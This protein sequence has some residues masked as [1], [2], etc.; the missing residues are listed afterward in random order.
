MRASQG[1]TAIGS[2]IYASCDTTSGGPNYLLKSSD[3]GSTWTKVADLEA[4]A[5]SLRITTNGTDTLY[6]MGGSGLFRR[7]AL[8]GTLLYSATVAGGTDNDII[9]VSGTTLIH[10]YLVTGFTELR[11][12]RS[13]DNGATW[14]APVTVDTAASGTFEDCRLGIAPD[15]TILL[16]AE[17]E[18]VNHFASAVCLWRSTD[19]GV[20]WGA[21]QTLIPVSGV[22]DNEGGDFVVVGSNI[23]LYWPSNAN[24]GTSYDHN[25]MWRIRSTD[26]GA[27]WGSPVQMTTTESHVAIQTVGVNGHAVLIS[28]RW[29]EFVGTPPFAYGAYVQ[30]LT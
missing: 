26:N 3:L 27:T 6:F 7:R 18:I 28:T 29:H 5:P 20:T 9:W 24:G 17:N 19:G 23:D 1:A 25:V 14:S 30:V 16:H 15:G 4:S 11:V 8:D 13:T 22:I 2:D 12:S 10:A 21:R